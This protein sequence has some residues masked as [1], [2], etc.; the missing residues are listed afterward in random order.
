MSGIFQQGVYVNSFS[1]PNSPSEVFEFPAGVITNSVTRFGSGQSLEV[2]GFSST[3]GKNLLTN[4]ASIITGFWFETSALPTTGWNTLLDLYDSTAGSNNDQVTL[5][6]SSSGALQFFRGTGQSNPLGTATASGLVS[7]NVGLYLE[8]GVTFNNTTGTVTLKVWGPGGGG[9]T[10]VISAS[11]L[12]TAPSGNNSVNR[13]YFASTGPGATQARH[14]F[15]DWYVL[16]GTGTSP[17][18][19]YLGNGTLQPD[20]ASMDASPNQFSTQP[21]QTSGNHYKNVDQ[22]P[23]VNDNDYN[24]DNN[25]GDIEAYGFLADLTSTP[26]FLNFV[27]RCWLD[28]SGSRTV[29]SICKSVSATTAGPVVIPSTTPSYFNQLVQN[30][31]N[32]GS[33]W[34]SASAAQ[35]AVLEIEVVT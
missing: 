17:L 31:P 23:L 7:P 3:C 8:I 27:Y 28:S 22:L 21:T 2:T 29:G 18:N 16:D 33:P 19:T 20:A 25:P 14:Y 32:T 4:L 6:Y 30:D 5:Q 34:A 11:G 13:F 26:L 1:Y 9:A 24:Y 10:P 12:N 35:A 15:Q